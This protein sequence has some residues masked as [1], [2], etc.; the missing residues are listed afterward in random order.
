[1]ACD[2]PPRECLFDHIRHKV[3]GAWDKLQADETTGLPYLMA[4]CP[5]HDDQKRSL[6]IS[7]GKQRRIV[8]YCHAGCSERKVRHALIGLGVHT[9][10][11]P[12]AAAELRDLEETLH[13]LLTSELGHAAVRIR[14]LALLTEPDGK[15]PGGSAL[16]ELAA[17]AKVSRREA[18][19]A[20]SA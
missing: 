16:D 6:K 10:C 14:A 15:I 3:P 17:A 1:V 11:L 8:F 19:R 7:V 12:R 5:A 9:G 13:D 2:V 18:Y 20:R 4:Y